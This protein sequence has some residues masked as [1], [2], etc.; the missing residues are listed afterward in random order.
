MRRFWVFVFLGLMMIVQP[1]YTSE[2]PTLDYSVVPAEAPP[3]PIRRIYGENIAPEVY[4][5]VATVDYRE[6]VREF[7]ENHS[8]YIMDYSAATEGSNLYARNYLIQQL[9]LLSNDRIEVETVG[10]HYNVVGRLP[11]YLPGDHPVIVVSAHYD[12]AQ[13]SD[14]ANSDASGIATVLILARIL[15]QYEWPLD[16]YFIA[17]NGLYTMDFMSGS[18]E[19]AL[20]FQQEE[21]EILTM[22]NVDTILVQNPSVPTNERIQMGYGY[23]GQTDYHR[24]QYW[25]DLT[26]MMSNNY[27]SNYVV[28]LPSSSFGLWQLSDH[29]TFA[30]RGFSGIL[31]AY[32][33]GSAIDQSSQT[34]DDRW[35]SPQYTYNIGR[36][37][38][39]VIGASIAFTMSR[40]Y[41]E[42]TH[43]THDFTNGPEQSEMFLFAVSTATVVNVTA[44]WFGGSSTYYLV[45]EGFNII[46][47]QEFNSSSPWQPMQIFNQQLTMK[48]TYRLYVQNTAFS[49]VGYEV[50]ITYNSDID[51]NGILD[52]NEYWLSQSYF[53]SDQ[54]G[55]NVSDADEIF[56]G[57][58]LNNKDTDSDTMD[59]RY[60]IDMGFNP[61]DASDGNEDADGDGL[62]N[63]QEYSGG[64]NPFSKDTDGDKMDDLWELTYGLNPLVD[65]ASLDPDG[66]HLT[67]LQEYKAG[68]D[69]NVDG[70]EKNP[71]NFFVPL[72]VVVAVVP[73]IGCLYIRKKNQEMLS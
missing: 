36:E 1:V 24:G 51:G 65:D 37:T 28:P 3:S 33:S 8:R 30:E 60:E 35:D 64:L 18:P 34:N 31:C 72:V 32:E 54:D 70:S 19:V 67:N 7:T 68:T 49:S 27:G 20:M 17:F 10:K 47:V 53:N 39:A 66:D 22:Y 11:G 71:P 48:G 14:G 23:G 13:N 57:T 16:I 21:I 26:R 50:S 69:P 9:G 43:L 73:V 59:D 15:S 52:K 58:D 46:D 40:E 56:H 44:R 45:D 38:T 29:Y 41:G 63:A 4:G 42:S 61:L 25:A 55:D 12:S 5:Q 2:S 62:T 6:Q